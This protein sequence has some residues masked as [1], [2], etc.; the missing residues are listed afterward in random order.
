ME[1]YDIAKMAEEMWKSVIGN[2]DSY[3]MMEFQFWE[4]WTEISTSA[5]LIYQNATPHYKILF[6]PNLLKCCVTIAKS[7]QDAD[8][9]QEARVL[10]KIWLTSTESIIPFKEAFFAAWNKT[11]GSDQHKSQQ[12]WTKI[13]DISFNKIL[14]TVSPRVEYIG[15]CHYTK[16][17]WNKTYARLHESSIH[18]EKPIGPLIKLKKV[19]FTYNWTMDDII[20]NPNVPDQPFPLIL[21]NSDNTINLHI[22]F[23]SEQDRKIWKEKLT[24]RLETLQLIKEITPRKKSNSNP[25]HR[26][27]NRVKH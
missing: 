11:M 10:N 7:P 13:F 18:I 27:A 14:S 26:T 24:H 16:G 15:I 3:A 23:Y 19:D 5:L 9:L 6:L 21:E 4:E 25:H 20:T 17:K 1:I 2:I 8:I 22:A 12:I